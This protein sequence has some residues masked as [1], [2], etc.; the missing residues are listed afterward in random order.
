[1]IRAGAA[2][3]AVVAL[4]GLGTARAE[5]AGPPV[6]RLTLHLLNRLAFGPTPES[7]AEIARI[8][9]DR[10][11]DQQLHPEAI[12]EP[13]SL[14]DR[15]G[16]LDTARLDTVAL[17]EQYG[18]PVRRGMPP[19]PEAAKA[20]RERA[21]IIVEQASDARLM[22]AI[23]SRRQ[24][25]EVMVDF[26][27]N[28]FNVFAGKGLD[29]L[30]VGNYED[31][32]IRPHA[33][34]RFR[35][36]L[37]ATA[38]H[39]AMMFFLDNWQ[40]SAPGSPGANGRDAG[41]NENYARELMELHTLGVDGGYTQADVIALARILTG[42][43]IVRPR[44]LGYEPSQNGF[45]FDPTRHDFG[46]KVFLGHTIRG[47]GADE[48]EQALD[49]LAA[50]PA[51]ARHL[52]YQLAQYFVADQPPPALVDRLTRRW[53]ASGGDIRAVLKELFAS[54]EFRNASD[55]D[56]KFKTP[57]EYVVSAVRASGVPVTNFRPLLGNMA[58][59]G[60]PLYGCQTPDGYKNTREAWLNPDAMALRL[61][62]ATALGSGHMP[63][64]RPPTEI[65]QQ[66]GARA[67]RMIR[68]ALAAPAPGPVIPLDSARLAA[69]LAPDLSEKTRAAV[70]AAPLPMRAALLLGSPEFMS[71]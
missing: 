40:N 60:E 4:L 24:L 10:W 46:D 71:R 57:F 35:D 55:F 16:Q 11:I 53:M 23:W 22:R 65:D 37:E 34:G 51:S 18:P 56:A 7:A 62:F 29:H 67:P 2:M 59:L 30:W 52:S 20:A 15:L 48:V 13:A 63:L 54:P 27:Y 9:V 68:L 25:Q 26:W 69:L 3:V 41:L 47:S 58:R 1:M 32:A 50:S 49:I 45:A 6:N 19:D 38:R 14:K 21:R 12:A 70:S 61:S 43:G 39:P 33:L 31:V 44:Q 64:D 36:L 17:F 66:E 8:G 42:W 28:H 5:E